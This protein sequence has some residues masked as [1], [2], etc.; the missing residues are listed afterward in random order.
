[1]GT[2]LETRP[3]YTPTTTFETFPFP[4]RGSQDANIEQ[5][6]RRLHQLREGWLNPLGLEGVD[7][8]KRTLTNLYNE[9]PGWLRNVNDE[10]DRAVHAAYG[11]PHPL[12]DTE[13]LRRLLELNLASPRP[14]AASSKP[15]DS[16]RAQVDQPDSEVHTPSDKSL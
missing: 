8:E 14:V 11:W 9:N 7:L 16:R 3:R 2:Q 6:A 1:M 15:R 4:S 10:L 13:I 5:A 12:S